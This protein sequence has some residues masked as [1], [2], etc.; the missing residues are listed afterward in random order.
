MARGSV[1]KGYVHRW[2]Y[3]TGTWNEKKV[4]AGRGRK[5]RWKFTYK[6]TKTRS[7]SK[8]GGPPVG[9]SV[10]WNVRGKQTARKVGPRKYV[11]T[12]RG[13]KSVAKTSTPRRRRRKK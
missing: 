12:F 8:R 5:N 7:G 4:S 1:P 13:T 11:T 3:H 9:Y 2:K 10:T 6:A